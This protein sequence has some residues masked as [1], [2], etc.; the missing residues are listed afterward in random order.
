ML[1]STE[2]RIKKRLKIYWWLLCVK[3]L[4]YSKTCKTLDFL[5]EVFWTI[6]SL[7]ENNFSLQK[8]KDSIHMLYQVTIFLNKYFASEQQLQ[9]SL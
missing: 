1:H 7:L 4:G 8:N 6:Y 9:E 2:V 3:K 5:R